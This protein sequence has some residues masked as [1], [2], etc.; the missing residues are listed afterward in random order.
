LIES[1]PN[2]AAVVV[3]FSCINEAPDQ[4]RR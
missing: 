3:R 4:A 1:A 2:A